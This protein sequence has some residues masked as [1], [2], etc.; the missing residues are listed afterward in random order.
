VLPV[1]RELAHY[2]PVSVDTKKEAVARFAVIA[3]ATIIND[4]SSTL[5]GLAGE[6]DVGYVAMHAKGDPRPCNS[7]RPTQD[8]VE[9][10]AAFLGDVA[11]KA[12]D[13]GVSPCGLIRALALVRRSRT[14]WPCSPTFDA[15]W[16]SPKSMARA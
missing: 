16:T 7:I 2:G 6:L 15:S 9:E 8:V 14:I 11:A 3:G 13:L 10:V 12:R 1:I 4:V 5:L